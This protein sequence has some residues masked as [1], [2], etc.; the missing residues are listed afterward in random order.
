[1]FKRLLTRRVCNG[2][3]TFSHESIKK[4]KA[5][6]FIVCQYQDL[7]YTNTSRKEVIILSSMYVFHLMTRL[8]AGVGLHPRQ[9]TLS[10]I[11]MIYLMVRKPP[12]HGVTLFGMFRL[13][14]RTRLQSGSLRVLDNKVIPLKY[15]AITMNDVTYQENLSQTYIYF[16]DNK[17]LMILVFQ[18]WFV[19]TNIC[20]HQERIPSVYSETFIQNI[21][22]IIIPKS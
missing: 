8:A 17:G 18:H 19:I 5:C 12:W 10:S 22:K 1:M 3:L 15:E 4:Y 16:G 2:P 6:W 20:C 7:Y 11:K 21:L 14:A 9:P 13:R